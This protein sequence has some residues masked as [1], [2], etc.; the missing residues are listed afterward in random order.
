MQQHFE[1]TFEC[2]T[3]MFSPLNLHADLLEEWND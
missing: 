3:A 1:S 2:S